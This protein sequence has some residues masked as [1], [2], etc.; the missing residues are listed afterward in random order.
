MVELKQR[1]RQTQNLITKR[2]YKFETKKDKSIRK[3]WE[4]NCKYVK[5]VVDGEPEYWIEF[6][7]VIAQAHKPENLIEFLKQVWED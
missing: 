4:K 7:G 2:R 6:G 3:Y 5:R 1:F